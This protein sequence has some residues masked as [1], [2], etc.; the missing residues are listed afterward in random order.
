MMLTS[1][2][3]PEIDPDTPI[4]QWWAEFVNVYNAGYGGARAPADPIPVSLP[5]REAREA[6][7]QCIVD[8]IQKYRKQATQYSPNQRRHINESWESNTPRLARWC[9]DTDS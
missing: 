8:L 2:K 9:V 7:R 5:D 3:M 4:L 1:W 6:L